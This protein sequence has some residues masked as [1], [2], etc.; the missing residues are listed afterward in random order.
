[1][2]K[3]QVAHA[4][5]EVAAAKTRV[6]V[7]ETWQAGASMAAYQTVDVSKPGYAIPIHWAGVRGAS[8]V[9]VTS[10]SLSFV[11]Q[12]ATQPLGELAFTAQGKSWVVT[13]PGGRAVGRLQLDGLKVKNDDG[14]FSPL[15]SGLSEST[16]LVVSIQDPSAGWLPVYS[17][18]AVS[19]RGVLPAMF[20]GASYSNK[21]LTLP[22]TVASPK[23]L[24]SLVKNP[25]PE[26]FELRDMQLAKITGWAAAA[27]R[28]L[29]LAGPDGAV[30]WSQPGDL[31]VGSAPISIDLRLPVQAALKATLAAAGG[32]D[33][34]LEVTFHLRGDPPSSVGIHLAAIHGALLRTFPGVIRTELQPD[35][36]SP[37]FASRLSGQPLANEAPASAAAD[38]TVRYA[39]LRILESVSSAVPAAAGNIGG[40]V[41][42]SQFAVRAFPPQALLN[43]PIARVGLIGRAPEACEL[44]VQL[45]DYSSGGPGP[46][47]GTAGVVELAPSALISTCWVDLPGSPVPT[48]PV[49]LSVRAN[50]GRFFWVCA[51]DPLI[52][53]AVRDPDPG[54][55]PLLLNGQPLLNVTQADEIHLPGQSF[56]GAAFQKVP[57]LL[58]SSLF[59][60]VELSDLVLRYQR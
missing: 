20:Q 26:D 5:Y 32:V 8:D 45:V 33:T 14:T 34:P 50:K 38:L 6:D 47:L 36:S 46:A 25:F 16:R 30:I 40:L 18:P 35:A 3:A 28:N 51:S 48:V 24:L 44:A 57:P 11:A 21:V 56:T 23:L 2:A 31:P 54:G 43:Q 4:D 29:E 58:E 9:E 42:S 10:G 7:A 22:G 15:N 12:T 53:L 19:S 60:T 59:L 52:R 17:V 39:G 27:P 55:R 1:M 13:I 49:G 37:D 41:V